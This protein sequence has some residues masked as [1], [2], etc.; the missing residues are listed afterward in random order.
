[1]SCATPDRRHAL[2]KICS[3]PDK[4]ARRQTRERQPAA[5]PPILQRSVYAA[6]S[7]HSSIH[8]DLEWACWESRFIVQ[9]ADRTIRPA[10]THAGCER[11]VI[12]T[13]QHSVTFDSGVRKSAAIWP[14]TT[15]LEA[16]RLEAAV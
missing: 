7:S 5:R 4:P 3:G 11:R 16:D 8:L 13:Q 12:A 10:K 1:M 6:N 2:R 15:Q 9:S 14:R